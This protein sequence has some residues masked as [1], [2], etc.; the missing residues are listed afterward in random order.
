MLLYAQEGIDYW[1]EIDQDPYK[2]PTPDFLES[3]EQTR[4]VAK[5]LLL[6]ALNANDD[7]AAFSAFRDNAERGSMD[8]RLKDAQ[9]GVILDQ[10]KA[11]HATNRSIA[12]QQMPAST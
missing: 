11:K 5:Q 6:V 1:K 9:L 3:E 8:K 2:I 12:S 4:A 7:K 10:L